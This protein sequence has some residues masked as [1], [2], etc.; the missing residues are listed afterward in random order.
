MKLRHGIMYTSLMLMMTTSYA[1]NNTSA[2]FNPAQTVAIQK[3]VHDYLV[4]NQQVL[5]EAATALQKQ[6]QQQWQ[7]TA[8]KAVPEIAQQLFANAESPVTGNP[9]G[10]VV[11]VEFFDYQCPHCKEMGP[12]IAGLL[13][14]D[15]NL[16]VVYKTLPIFG[17]N[18]EFAAKAA[19]AAEKQGKFMALHEALL[20][21]TQDRLTNDVVLKLAQQAGLNIKQLQKDMQ[22]PA[23]AQELKS[24]YAL[25][26]TL[27]L[28]GTPGFVFAKA[29]IDDKTHQVTDLKNP[30][31]IPG[32]V[33]Q[34]TLAEAIT[35]TRGN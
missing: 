34:S 29:T 31:L 7:D 33:D 6:Q 3:I 16:R 5:M 1:Q 15:K 10:D 8:K 19:L 32:A 27:Q 12:E 21:S 18:S 11:M 14:T 9:K 26:K 4:N 2:S 25:A 23:I 28:S 22:D 30:L 13:T 35:Q 20:N 17:N 24:N